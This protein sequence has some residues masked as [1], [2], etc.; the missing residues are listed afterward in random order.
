MKKLGPFYERVLNPIHPGPAFGTETLDKLKERAL[1]FLYYCKNV[2]NTVDLSLAPPYNT[3]FYKDCLEYLK[4]QR[5]L[6][7]SSFKPHNCC[8]L[9]LS[10]VFQKWCETLAKKLNYITFYP[11]VE[12]RMHYKISNPNLKSSFF[13]LMQENQLRELLCESSNK[14]GRK[15]IHAPSMWSAAKKMVRIIVGYLYNYLV[16]RV[17]HC[18]LTMN[19]EVLIVLSCPFV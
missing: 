1:C 7:P 6:K 10:G 12:E 14:K 15:H 19:H 8:F 17:N 13:G 3:N 9:T 16:R 2:K 4:E 18:V 11:N 5:K